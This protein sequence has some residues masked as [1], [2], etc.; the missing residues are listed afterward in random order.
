MLFFALSVN[1]DTKQWIC[2]LVG[3]F[4][5]P[6]LAWLEIAVHILKDLA[7]HDRRFFPGCVLVGQFLTFAVGMVFPA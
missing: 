3:H 7:G 1:L 2:K 4:Q 5:L 6:R